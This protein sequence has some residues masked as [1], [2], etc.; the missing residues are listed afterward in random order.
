MLPL[1]LDFLAIVHT[2]EGDLDSAKAVLHEAE[3]IAEATH[4]ERIGAARLTLGGFR[5]EEVALGKLVETLEPASAA[6][7][8]GIVLTFG[9]Y[10]RAVLYN[11]LGRY[12]LA[13]TEAASAASQDDLGAS[14]WSLPELVEAAV[15]C[16]R[17]EVA[18]ETVQELSTRT[19]AAGTHWALGIEARSRAL[20]AAGSTAEALYREA[21]EQL[22][23]CR[24]A[25]ERA[26]AH[27]LYGEWLRREGRRIDA[28]EQL[29][30]AHEMFVAMG[31]NAFADRASR[32]LI[33][34]GEKIRK[35][36]DAARG[37]LTAQEDQIARLARSGQSNSEIAAQLF[38]S[39]RTIEWHLRHVY[40]KLGITSR[41]Q[42]Q[43]ALPDGVLAGTYAP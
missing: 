10:A 34:G 14:V 30:R 29:R 2:F 32:E 35:R 27:L 16:G 17:H 37:Q 3:A 7:G 18:A 5:G 26:R 13:L 11:G 31:M 43:D 6:R 9:E 22:G 41:R 42:L 38:L 15:R 36:N 20:L 28:R 39:T 23:R 4:A 40:M 21:I 1:A 33:A 24:V 8:E 12:E 19:Q 25:P